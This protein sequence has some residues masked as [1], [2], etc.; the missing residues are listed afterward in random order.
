MQVALHRI[1]AAGRKRD[2]CERR[3]RAQ[4]R[5]RLFFANHV[6]RFCGRAGDRI[7]ERGDKLF[8]RKNRLT[9]EAHFAKRVAHPFVDPHRDARACAAFAQLDAGRIDLHVEIALGKIEPAHAI[10]APRDLGLGERKLRRLTRQPFGRRAD[11]VIVQRLV[12]NGVI[13]DERDFFERRARAFVDAHDDFSAADFIIDRGFRESLFPVKCADVKCRVVRARGRHP[14]LLDFAHLP[15]DRREQLVVAKA[16]VAVNLDHFAHF[17]ADCR[18]HEIGA[19][20]R[21]LRLAI[22]RT[23]KRRA[24]EK[25]RE[26]E[27]AEAWRRRPACDECGRRL[28]CR[29]Q[30]RRL[31]H[32]RQAGR[33]PHAARL[34]N[35]HLRCDHR[36]RIRYFKLPVKFPSTPR[37][38]MR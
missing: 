28:A 32:A 35:F 23:R 27:K 5:V 10:A 29:G 25:Q 24:C 3:R 8:A 20:H 13:A 11:H 38:P 7:A 14:L 30:A 34:R 36:N 15:G 2:A 37:S 16:R 33:L 9:L 1:R 12:R 21:A 26:G 4:R 18:L 19:Q 6:L 22:L 17:R 31:P